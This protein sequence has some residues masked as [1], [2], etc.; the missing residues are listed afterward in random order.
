MSY[1]RW[2]SSDSGSRAGPNT[3]VKRRLY[4][5]SP[6][7]KLKYSGASRKLPSSRTCT[8]RRSSSRYAGSPNAA[9]AITLPSPAN[10]RKP[11]W[12]VTMAYSSPTELG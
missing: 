5:R 12:V 7:W 6:R 4:M 10:T 1:C 8:T 9:R 3:S 11:R 2:V